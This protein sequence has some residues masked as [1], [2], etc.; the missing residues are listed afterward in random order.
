MNNTQYMEKTGW[1]SRLTQDVAK[2]Q[3]VDN[4]RTAAISAV[5]LE[6]VEDQEQELAKMISLLGKLDR[7]GRKAFRSQLDQFL[8][9]YHPDFSMFI[10][11]D[12]TDGRGAP[13]D[14]A[15][16]LAQGGYTTARGDVISVPQVSVQQLKNDLLAFVKDA[17]KPE[18]L[19]IEYKKYEERVIELEYAIKAIP[20]PE[21]RDDM[22]PYDQLLEIILRAEHG[23]VPD[24]SII[25][26]FLYWTGFDE[27]P[28]FTAVEDD[29][30]NTVQRSLKLEE[31]AGFGMATIDVIQRV[32]DNLARLNNFER[33]RR[34]ALAYVRSKRFMY[35]YVQKTRVQA[36]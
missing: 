6:G 3:P 30:G 8:A 10:G 19:P 36:A 23:R 21:S 14:A 24:Q 26:E 33:I 16:I 7:K 5:T 20:Q 29:Y 15:E 11:M 9:Q 27:Q 17:D 12:V 31:Y 35:E 2:R 25:A 22:R 18:P 1:W 34:E 28:V 32:S 13:W 4:A